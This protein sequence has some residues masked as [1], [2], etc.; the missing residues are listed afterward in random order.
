MVVRS[1]FVTNSSSS[2]FVALEIDSK[3]IL[4]IFREFE[5]VIKATFSCSNGFGNE[6]DFDEDDCD[7][8]GGDLCGNVTI[9][10]DGTISIYVDEAYTDLPDKPEDFVPIL[11]NLF[12]EGF[13]EEYCDSLEYDDQLDMSQYSAITQ[14][15]IAVKDEIM[16]NLKNFTVASGESGWGGDSDCRY[17]ES[18]YEPNHLKDVKAEIAE[19]LGKEVDEITED[20]FCKYVGDKISTETDI[21]KY[22][23][24]TKKM[25]TIRT[26]DLQ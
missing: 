23:G 16:A 25:T 8:D 19:S 14:R 7:M 15:L 1:S 24:E 20:E 9:N 26:T 3:E 22:D 6:E 18:W 13:Y 21:C 11:A 10:D 5:D 2:S 12:D 17:E 4:E